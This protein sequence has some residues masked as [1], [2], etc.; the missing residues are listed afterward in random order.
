[1]DTFIGGATR[2][3]LIKAAGY[4]FP[5]TTDDLFNTATSGRKS[6]A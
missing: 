1:V 2:F 4:D 5:D 3:D 6:V